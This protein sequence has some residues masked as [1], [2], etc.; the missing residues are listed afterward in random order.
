MVT[1][2]CPGG[3]VMS[4]HAGSAGTDRV[5]L[6]FHRPS[7]LSSLAPSPSLADPWLGL[8][9]ASLLVPLGAGEPRDTAFRSGSCWLATESGRGTGGEGGL[10][11]WSLVPTWACPNPAGIPKVWEEHLLLRSPRSLQ[12]SEALTGVWR[13]Y[14]RQE[15]EAKESSPVMRSEASACPAWGL[16]THAGCTAYKK[17][18]QKFQEI[19]SPHPT[20]GHW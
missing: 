6:D 3:D 17:S 8:D 18:S 9:L 2:A 20:F 12:P 16:G 11:F 19:C 10:P 13:H 14:W 15:T 4:K 1:T 5:L 7:S